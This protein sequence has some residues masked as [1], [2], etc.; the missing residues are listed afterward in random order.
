[1]RTI[2]NAYNKKYIKY[3][4]KY[5]QFKLENELEGKIMMLDLAKLTC[6]TCCFPDKVTI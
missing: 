1:M 6:I 4:K 3:K 5:L 2:Y